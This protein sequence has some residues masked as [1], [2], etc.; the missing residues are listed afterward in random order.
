MLREEAGGLRIEYW[1]GDQS[2]GRSPDDCPASN[3]GFH[4]GALLAAKELG[5]DV[6]AADIE[7]AIAGYRCLFNSERGFMPTSRKLRDLGASPSSAGAK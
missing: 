2:V 1:S 3:Q 6:S 7:R 5:L 4:C